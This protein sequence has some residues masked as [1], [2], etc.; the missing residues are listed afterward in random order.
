MPLYDY[1]CQKCGSQESLQCHHINPRKLS[2]IEES[3][4]DN[5][6]KFCKKCHKWI[7]SFKGCRYTDL[8]NCNI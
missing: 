6:I 2:P 8:A 4:P 5:G 7:H 1:E 3:D